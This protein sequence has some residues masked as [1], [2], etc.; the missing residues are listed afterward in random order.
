ML[1][2]CCTICD[3]IMEKGSY[4]APRMPPANASLPASPAPDRQCI[5]ANAAG[6]GGTDTYGRP[7]LHRKQQEHISWQRLDQSCLQTTF[8]LQQ[9]IS[10]QY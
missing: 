10:T 7:M 5:F 9:L 4:C 1:A 2:I 6:D 3:I 8:D